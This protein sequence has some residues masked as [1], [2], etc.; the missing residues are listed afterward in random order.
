MRDHVISHQ[1]LSR[2]GSIPG[3]LDQLEQIQSIDGHLLIVKHSIPQLHPHN[4]GNK[5]S[6]LAIP[7]LDAEKQ[8]GHKIRM[9]M[10]LVSNT[11][12]QSVAKNSEHDV[13]KG[14][15]LSAITLAVFTTLE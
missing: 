10:V 9:H 4:V 11:R 8:Q 6:G 13:S 5:Q 15:E 2:K 3:V 12:K 1:Q 14:N 7:L